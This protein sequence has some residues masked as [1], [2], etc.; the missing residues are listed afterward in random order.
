MRNENADADDE[1]KSDLFPPTSEME[2]P[3]TPATFGWR[4]FRLVN[5]HQYHR[6]GTGNRDDITG[7]FD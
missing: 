1:A 6:P 5:S 3:I 4:H 2:F 7:I